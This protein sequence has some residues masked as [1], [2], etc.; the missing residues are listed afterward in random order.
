MM[1]RSD[2]IFQAGEEQRELERLQTIERIFDPGTQHR[3]LETG[4][5]TGWR[6]LEVGAGAGSIV[7]WL[8]QRVGPSGKVVALDTNLRYLRGSGTATIEVVQGD[9]CEV[10]LPAAAFDLVHARYVLIHVADYRLAF[11]R[12]LHCVKPGG[13]I[14]IEEPDFS[15]ARAIIATDQAKLSFDRVTKAIERMFVSLGMDYA[16]GS[17]LPSLFH[18]HHLSQVTVHHEG[19]LASGG[20]PVPRLMKLSAEQ[21]LEKYVETGIA[22][23]ADVEAYRRF[24]DDPDSWAVY[25]ATVAVTGWWQPQCEGRTEA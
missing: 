22:T 19:H 18:R 2:Y 23:E 13:Y 11:E 5:S 1:L 14:V 4:L 17:K 24:A 21:L 20:G 3:L 9:I 8:E 16:A 6:C 7:R 12:M 15:A 10:D 25:Y